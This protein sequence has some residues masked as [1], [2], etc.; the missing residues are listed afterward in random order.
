[1]FQEALK[2]SLLNPSGPG[3]LLLGRPLIRASIS[4][5]VKG[6][7]KLSRSELASNRSL[8]FIVKPVNSVIPSLSLYSCQS[9]CSFSEW[10]ATVTP[11]AEDRWLISFLLFLIVAL[12]WKNFVPASPSWTHLIEPLFSSR[13]SAY[14][15]APAGV[16]LGFYESSTQIGS[17]PYILTL[18]PV[19]AKW[20]WH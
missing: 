11:W 7:S 20:L 17:D 15:K 9:S 14:L 13:F 4:S 18:L 3:D 6:D 2:N 16:S 10:S 8:G 5:L 12:A 1:M 19:A